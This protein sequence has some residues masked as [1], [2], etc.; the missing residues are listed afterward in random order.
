MVSPFD[1]VT[2]AQLRR[3]RPRGR[4][5]G[6]TRGWEFPLA[7]AAVLQQQFGRRFTVTAVLEEWLAAC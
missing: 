4:W 7:A 6:P 1:A 2:Q 5:H 3:I